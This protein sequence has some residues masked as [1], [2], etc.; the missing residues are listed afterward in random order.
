MVRK[1]TTGLIRLLFHAAHAI[2]V[3]RLA[4]GQLSGWRLPALSASGCARSVFY[5]W[6]A[7][8]REAKET[9]QQWSAL[10]TLPF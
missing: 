7:A 8:Q 4:Y 1:R 2:C 6:S 3:S 9:G 10:T 5:D